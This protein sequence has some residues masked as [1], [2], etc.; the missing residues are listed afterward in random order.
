MIS[1]RSLDR[2]QPRL[3]VHPACSAAWQRASFGKTRSQVRSLPRR[4]NHLRVA[5]SV[6][7]VLWEHGV[8]SSSLSAE[9]NFIGVRRLTAGS[10]PA[11]PTSISG[12]CG[13][14][15]ALRNVNPVV[16]GSIPTTHPN[17]LARLAEPANAA[18]SKAVAAR[19]AG[20]RPASGTSNSPPRGG[21][22]DTH[23]SQKPGPTGM[24]VRI[25]PRG[26]T[27]T[28]DSSDGPERHPHKVRVSGSNPLRATSTTH[29]LNSAAQSTWLLPRES[30]VRIPEPVPDPKGRKR[31]ASVTW[32]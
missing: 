20:S 3:P 6:A 23:R 12:A 7:H 28:R 5:Q 31:A 19:H 32:L 9:T 27:S 18:A 13:A 14:V 16:V 22:R 30:R 2:T 21:I 11:I 8:G 24:S 15:A 10:S 29:G 25:G 4:P 1:E 17:Q 26:P